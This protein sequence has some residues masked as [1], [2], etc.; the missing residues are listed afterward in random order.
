MARCDLDDMLLATLY[1]HKYEMRLS[2]R[3]AGIL[4]REGLLNENDLTVYRESQSAGLLTYEGTQ[5]YDTRRHSF[6]PVRGLFFGVSNATAT[7]FL[8]AGQLCVRPW[9]GLRSL[10]WGVPRGELDRPRTLCT[11][12]TKAPR[13]SRR[14]G[15]SSRRVR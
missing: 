10:F 6:D 11:T 1:S 5:E 2:A 13:P 9:K 15:R 3:A 12:S 7:A 14:L 4:L 8:G